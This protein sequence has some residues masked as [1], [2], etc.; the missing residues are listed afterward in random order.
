MEILLIVAKRKEARERER[1]RQAALAEH[2]RD[3][4]AQLLEAANGNLVDC[5]EIRDLWVI[6]AMMADAIE[7]DAILMY[8]RCVADRL[9][10]S[11]PASTAV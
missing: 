11:S 7:L 8:V 3:L 1:G 2:D 6:K 9:L 4:L 10:A 5:T